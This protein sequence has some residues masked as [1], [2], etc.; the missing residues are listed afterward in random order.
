MNE[1]IA[2]RGGCTTFNYFFAQSTKQRGRHITNLIDQPVITNPPNTVS[3]SFQEIIPKSQV[4]VQNN[5]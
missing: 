5:Y 1:N 2:S 4:N 3:G